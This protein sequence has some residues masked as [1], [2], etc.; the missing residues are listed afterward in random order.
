M[1][2]LPSPGEKIYCMYPTAFWG[3]SCVDDDTEG[4]NGLLLHSVQKL[5]RS[6]AIIR[7]DHVNLG[8]CQR[9]ERAALFLTALRL[10]AQGA[11][12]S[13]APHRLLVTFR[14]APP[15]A[16]PGLA[17]AG[18][19]GRYKSVRRKPRPLFG[20]RLSAAAAGSRAGA[21]P[22]ERAMAEEG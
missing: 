6:G 11:R 3:T 2:I 22:T 12:R 15:R 20:V 10:V 17:R 13:A 1:C 19:L 9:E 18:V 21:A 8:G 7:G 16:A 4:G 5:F 14:Q